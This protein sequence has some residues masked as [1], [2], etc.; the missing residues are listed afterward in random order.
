MT[1]EALLNVSCI[2]AGKVAKQ[3]FINI[4][5]KHWLTQTFLQSFMGKIWMSKKLA[6][7][8][9]FSVIDEYFKKGRQK[10]NECTLP[11]EWRFYHFPVGKLKSQIVK[12]WMNGWV[13]E[14][15]SYPFSN[16]GAG[17]ISIFKIFMIFMLMTI[18]WQHTFMMERES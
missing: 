8:G 1:H 9:Q 15:F 12:F 2:L 10:I 4:N 11:N 7:I 5:H 3:T 17:D 6:K 14:S 18:A 16:C 13:T